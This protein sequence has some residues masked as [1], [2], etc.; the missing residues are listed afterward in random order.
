MVKVKYPNFIQI[1]AQRARGIVEDIRNDKRGE[2]ARL[3]VETNEE[4]IVRIEKIAAEV[5]EKA[6]YLV[7][8]GVGGSYL[9][10]RAVIEALKHRPETE[11]KTQVLF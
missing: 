1:D 11:R 8:T 4:E 7:C 10:H 5:R 3:P 2:W 6:D 9:G